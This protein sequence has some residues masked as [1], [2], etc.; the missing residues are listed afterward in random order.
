MMR[1]IIENL[2]H[3]ERLERLFNET[4]V[5]RYTRKLP[6]A[7]IAEVMG[8]VVFNV[9]PSVGASLTVCRNDLWMA[10]RNFCVLAFLFGIILRNAR[11]AIRILTNLLMKAAT[12]LKVADLSTH[13]QVKWQN[14]RNHNQGTNVPRS[15]GTRRA[16]S[17]R[18]F[19]R[20]S[21]SRETSVSGYCLRNRLL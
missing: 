6:F 12:A 3:P 16:A 14:R 9:S 4:A 11:F 21:A 18:I 20:N 5:A 15:P 19:A 7:T 17:L 13:A 1:G 10:D 8:E 2:F